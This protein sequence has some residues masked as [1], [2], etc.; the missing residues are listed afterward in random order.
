M[1]CLFCAVLLGCEGQA[2]KNTPEAESHQWLPPDSWGHYD[3]GLHTIEWTDARGKALQADIWYP[4]IADDSD[5]LAFYEPTTLSINAYRRAAPAVSNAPLLAFS[6]GFFAIRFQSAFLME[7][8]ARHGFVVIATD[9]PRN[10]ILD[11]DDDATVEVLLE[12]PDDIRASIDE[13][14]SRTQ[15]PDD[16]LYGIANTDSY[17]AMGHSFGSHTAMV[18]GGGELDYVGLMSYCETYPDA[19]PCRYLTDVDPSMVDLHGGADDRVVATVPMSPG[20]WYTF[21]AEAEGLDALTETLVLA[22]KLDG[23]LSYE[24]EA[25][26][27][28]SAMGEPKILA[29]VPGAGHYG[30]TDICT[31]AEAL[32][33]ECGSMDAPEFESIELIKSMTQTLVMAYLG[34]YILNDERYEPWLNQEQWDE[35]LLILE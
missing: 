26:P 3:A 27:A 19:R 20:L 8:L 33:P 25:L 4:A 29:S 21:G 31:L 6:H 2:P 14:E 15:D 17:V 22:G 32:T 34:R 9:H 10:T 30:F 28:F 23:V 35:S 12:R 18:L 13:L 16:F 1:I 7:H 24:Q 5:D 11:F